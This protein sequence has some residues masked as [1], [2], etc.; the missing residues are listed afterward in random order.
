MY[1]R[2]VV[3]GWWRVGQRQLSVAGRNER[4][5]RTSRGM[6]VAPEPAGRRLALEHLEPRRLPIAP[7]KWVTQAGVFPVGLAQWR[8][9]R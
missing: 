3:G 7:A 6:P 1:K 4:R 2:L 5:F 8:E 9:V